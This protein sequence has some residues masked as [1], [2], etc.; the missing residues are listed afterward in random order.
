MRICDVRSARMT[1]SKSQIS[2]GLERDVIS[3]EYFW[4][5]EEG[6]MKARDKTLV[7]GEWLKNKFANSVC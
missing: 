5:G 7:A 6:I 2:N 3:R 4:S 1:V